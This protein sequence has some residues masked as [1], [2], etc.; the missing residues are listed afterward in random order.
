MEIMNKMT[1][2]LTPL[3]AIRKYCK[4]SCCSNDTESWEKCHVTNCPLFKY[5]FGKRKIKK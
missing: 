1:K 5:R 2:K 3:Q 4:K